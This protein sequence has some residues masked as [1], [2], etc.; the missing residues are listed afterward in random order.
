M[1]ESAP[2][3]NLAIKPLVLQPLVGILSSVGLGKTYLLYL[4]PFGTSAFEHLDGDLF[5][6]NVSFLNEKERSRT[7]SDIQTM[8]CPIGTFQKVKAFVYSSTCSITYGMGVV[9]VPLYIRCDILR[10]CALQ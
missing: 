10:T 5:I 7:D 1:A 9:W 6:S 2:S 4:V 8:K 3:G